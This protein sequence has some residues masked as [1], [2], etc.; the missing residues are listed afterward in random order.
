MSIARKISDAILHEIR[1]F[2]REYMRETEIAVKRRLQKLLIMGVIV[3]VLTA[4]VISLLGSA[5]LFL[6]VGSLKYLET[7]MPA[8]KA[9]DIMGLT[10][11]VVGAVLFL[12][13]F[14]IIKKQIQSL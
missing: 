4:L 2:L 10:A 7:S 5:A 11:G 12:V 9:W 8:W 6:L 1:A 14:M 3:S 13:L